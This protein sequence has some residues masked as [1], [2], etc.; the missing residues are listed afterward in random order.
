M[1]F[2]RS[3]TGAIN[4]V[5]N[6]FIAAALATFAAL[7]LSVFGSSQW[8]SADGGTSTGGPVPPESST[9]GAPRHVTAIPGDESAAVTWFKPAVGDTEIAEI[10]GYVITASPS[11]ISVVSPAND[12][13]VIV[14]GLENG[15]E[16]TFTIFATNAD[17]AGEISEPSNP[18]TPEAGLVLN[19]Q[20]LKRLRAHLAKRAHEAR[21]RVREAAERAREQM[22]RT[23]ER[24]G[25]KLQEQTEHAN[26][27]LA[28][29]T[30]K[31]NEQN[32]RQTE[33]ANNWLERLRAQLAKKLE[34]AEGTDRYEE[35][36]ARVA[37][38]TAKAEAKAGDRIAKSDEKTDARIAKANE[39]VE[40]RLHKAEERAEKAVERTKHRLT[41]KMSNFRDRLQKMLERLRQVWLERGMQQGGDPQGQEG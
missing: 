36:E 17:G 27:H 38:T 37:E 31:A 4:P 35:L 13:L 39:S 11:G 32:A 9:P 10:D 1:N 22:Q 5:A 21:E 6:R 18:V 7:V 26:E 41:E 24:V 20:R 8:A 30:E 23:R 34:R 40:K 28:K 19:E 12:M 3:R 33:Q 16:Y 2:S 29:T 15:V 14:E 25:E